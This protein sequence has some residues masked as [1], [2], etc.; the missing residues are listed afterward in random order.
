MIFKL[1]LFINQHLVR[2][3]L[4]KTNNEYNV[5]AWKS[6]GIII[7]NLDHYMILHLPEN[8]LKRKYNCNSVIAF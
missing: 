5:S 1:C 7:P 2:W 4:K 6:K 3:T 8:I